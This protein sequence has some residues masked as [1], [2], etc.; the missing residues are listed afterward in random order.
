MTTHDAGTILIVLDIGNDYRPCLGRQLASIGWDGSVVHREINPWCPALGLECHDRLRPAKAIPYDLIEMYDDLFTWGYGLLTKP[1]G[2]WRAKA[3]NR[4]T[5]DP[6]PCTEENDTRDQYGGDISILV[7]G[8]FVIPKRGRMSDI[9]F[10]SSQFFDISSQ[11]SNAFIIAGHL[12]YRVGDLGHIVTEI[13]DY[14]CYRFL[15]VVLPDGE[16]RD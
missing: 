5:H 2:F 9:S 3:Q 10:F 15:Q 13:K 16:A 11:V 6:I 14:R 8:I 7:R 12:G 4:G 1:Y